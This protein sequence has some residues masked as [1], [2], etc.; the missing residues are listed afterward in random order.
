MDTTTYLLCTRLNKMHAEEKERD[1]HEFVTELYEALCISPT[2]YEQ[3]LIEG[4]EL[5]EEDVRHVT[6]ERFRN[7]LNSLKRRFEV[8]NGFSPS[9]K[10]PSFYLNVVE[11]FREEMERM[12]D[13]D[14]IDDADNFELQAHAEWGVL[15]ELCSFDEMTETAF[16]LI[17]MFVEDIPGFDITHIPRE[18]QHAK[19]MQLLRSNC[20]KSGRTWTPSDYSRGSYDHVTHLR[21]P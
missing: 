14:A 2:E 3:A 8:M 12:M 21:D 9:L 1:K 11:L 20:E 7:F 15:Q 17:R 19:V 5:D 10:I 13:T 4:H 6:K 18:R 16:K